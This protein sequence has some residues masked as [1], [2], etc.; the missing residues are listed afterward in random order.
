[1]N[2]SM[3]EDFLTRAKVTQEQSTFEARDARVITPATPP[4]S[5]SSP[6]KMQTM[7][8]TGLLGLMLG[9]GA[10][11]SLELLNTGFTTA[12]QIEDALELPVL[13]SVSKMSDK[14][15][16]VNGKIIPLPLFP[17]VKPL[18]RYSEALR[19][20]RSGIQMT[21]VDHPPK[22]IQVTSTVPSEGKTSVALGLATSAANSSLKVLLIDADLRNPS[23][24]RFLKLDKEPGL[25]ELLLGE[26]NAND[27]VRFYQPGQ[28]W[29]LNS[30][31]RTQNP[32]D[33]LG[34]ERMKA[35]INSFA[36]AFD[37]ILVDTPPLGPV[38]DPLIVSQLVEKVL[39]VI[40]WS[41][42]PREIV[43]QSIKKL[44]NDKKVAGIVLNYTDDRQVAKYGKSAYAYY[45]TKYY[46]NYYTDA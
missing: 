19:S 11:V 37:Y 12:T 25:V 29:S 34:S 7:L 27:V 32:P 13:A 28:F 20:L 16:T 30:G 8:I 24:S 2:K 10:A 44:M 39:Y 41:D 14:E 40:R 26:V 23:A 33:L 17:A 5:P 1:M 15:L 31:G 18:S 38:I 45:G 42:T 36:N 4:T 46:K 9:V 21:D 22:V 35:L 3:F 6:K 43:E